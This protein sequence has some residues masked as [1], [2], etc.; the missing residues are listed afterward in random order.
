M[1]RER[2]SD[3]VR[4]QV[5]KPRSARHV[6]GSRKREWRSFS[7]RRFF[8]ETRK[9]LQLLHPSR[10]QVRL[11]PLPVWLEFATVLVRL[12]KSE[13]PRRTISRAVFQTDDDLIV[14]SE[15][16]RFV[17]KR[18]DFSAPSELV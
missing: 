15:K 5:Q 9:R 17:L 3:R 16:G 7:G 18:S 10:K 12:G 13:A 1:P 14:Y 6:S 8:L 2:P 11:Q 4:H